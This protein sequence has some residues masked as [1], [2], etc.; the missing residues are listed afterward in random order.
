L[1]IIAATWVVVTVAATAVA[2]QAVTFVTAQITSEPT[3]PIEVAVAPA[4][5]LGKSGPSEST[6]STRRTPTPSSATTVGVTAPSSTNKAPTTTEPVD[7]NQPA[8]TSP[9][10]DPSSTA[11]S[12]TPPSSATETRRTVSTVGG[13]ASASCL[14]TQIRLLSSTPSA[15]YSQ[16]IE[17]SGPHEIQL[18]YWS[19]NHETSVSGTCLGGRPVINVRESGDS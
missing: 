1:L 17:Q 18:R 6:S 19:P 12:S 15:G 14:G 5:S 7:S 11:S 10:H 8:A 13:I 16:T 2:W 3:R 9:N 4:V